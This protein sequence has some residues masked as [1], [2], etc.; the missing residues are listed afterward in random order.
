MTKTNSL[1]QNDNMT[2]FILTN[3]THKKLRFTEFLVSGKLKTSTSSLQRIEH[4]RLALAVFQDSQKEL[5]TLLDN[6]KPENIESILEK[7]R[8]LS[9]ADAFMQQIDSDG[10]A[11]LQL[12][13]MLGEDLQEAQKAFEE[14]HE[15]K[16]NLSLKVSK[17]LLEILIRLVLVKGNLG[18]T[19]ELCFYLLDQA[20]QVP[21]LKKLF[22]SSQ[23]ELTSTLNDL[24]KL[25]KLTYSQPILK[26]NINVDNFCV[27][28]ATLASSQF[29][30]GKSVTTD[31]KFIYLLLNF[32]AGFM[33]KI[34]TGQFN[35]IKGKVYLRKR[36]VGSEGCK[37]TWCSGSLYFY[38]PSASLEILKEIST[39]TFEQ[40]GVFKMSI[41][42]LA[43][44][45]IARVYNIYSALMAEGDNIHLLMV[46][47]TQEK[48]SEP[49]VT[50]QCEIKTADRQI[51][52]KLVNNFKNDPFNEP[53]VPIEK[54]QVSNS[55]PMFEIAA[56]M[57]ERQNKYLPEEI[58]EEMPSYIS[59]GGFR[60]R[61]RGSFARENEKLANIFNAYG[62]RGQSRAKG[63]YPSGNRFES[64]RD[65]DDG[66]YSSFD[67]GEMEE[68]FY[69]DYV[70]SEIIVGEEHLNQ[71]LRPV[72]KEPKNASKI[73]QDKLYSA[74]VEFVKGTV[75]SEN[76]NWQE[77]QRADYKYAYQNIQPKVAARQVTLPKGNNLKLVLYTFSVK[78]AVNSKLLKRRT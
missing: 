28:F 48:E 38:Q 45:K 60:G 18:E 15:E 53:Q 37:W 8:S 3:Q 54:P 4:P 51:F 10:S 63:F 56:S 25:Y 42:A 31:G 34:G 19:L 52:K 43:S 24:R 62:G 69:R 57:Q 65:Y 77:P 70:E 58:D 29:K 6:I 47:D 23:D 40:I 32:N 36:M 41:P 33:L 39:E 50:E 5:K 67:Q 26:N 66:S 44:T 14:Q 12:K 73:V 74:P 9:I 76:R 20:D 21:L 78:V 71:G 13:E 22:S 17:I 27:S 55:R 64:R 1:T 59:R 30:Q 35:T 11:S 2:N 49:V 46:E 7:L 16:H 61:V 72:F 68:A 75:A